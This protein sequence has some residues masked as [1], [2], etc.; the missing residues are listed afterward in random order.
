VDDKLAATCT[1][2][3]FLTPSTILSALM[4]T[5]WRFESIALLVTL[6]ALL[7]GAA[8]WSAARARGQQRDVGHWIFVTI[9]SLGLAMVFLMPTPRAARAG[10]LFVCMECGHGVRAAEPFCYRCGAA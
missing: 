3:A 2:V 6:A 5:P 7:V 4:P 8:L 1:T 9:I 10:T